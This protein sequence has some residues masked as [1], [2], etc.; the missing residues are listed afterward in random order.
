MGWALAIPIL[1]VRVAGY[2]PS[3]SHPST[4]R[5]PGPRCTDTPWTTRAA[6]HLGHAHMTVLDLAKE[7][8]G[9]DNALVHAGI[10]QGTPRLCRALPATLRLGSP[11][12]PCA[13][14]PQ[15]YL[16]SQSYL[17]Y[18]SDISGISYLRYLISQVSQISQVSHI[19]VISQLYLSYL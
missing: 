19:S 10:G 18:I 13:P 6:G 11:A 5:R 14:S 2:Y 7:I 16:I 9:V 12:P 8:L 15:L 3:P 1:G 4:A 17:S